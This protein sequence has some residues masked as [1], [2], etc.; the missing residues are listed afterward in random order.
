MINVS[1]FQIDSL[2]VSYDP[3]TDILSVGV[4]GPNNAQTNQEVIAGDSDNNL[5]SATVDPSVTA[6]DSQFL[7][8]ADMG[9]TKT[10]GIFLELTN[11]TATDSPDIV[12]GFPQ[13]P[14]AN[15]ASKP[16]V[17]AKFANNPGGDMFDPDNVFPQYTGNFFLANDPA[18][19]NFELQIT[20]FSQLYQQ[21]T[22]KTFSTPT[23][24][25]GS[26]RSPRITRTSGSAT[27]PSRP[28]H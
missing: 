24:R 22:G 15:G 17:V 10:Y 14:P 16:Y 27:S 28:S 26:G 3:T 11:P 7:D 23:T 6:I 9:G 1:G 13:T 25:S 12:A 18:H 21:V 5:N 2:S 20:H 19:P 8:P 4:E